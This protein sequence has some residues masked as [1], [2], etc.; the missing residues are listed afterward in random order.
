MECVVAG[1]C[2]REVSEIARAC[3]AVG[4]DGS[5]RRCVMNCM[6]SSF[7]RFLSILMSSENMHMQVAI[8]V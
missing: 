5:Y 8:L 2:A 1:V 6:T 7:S 4:D 3:W